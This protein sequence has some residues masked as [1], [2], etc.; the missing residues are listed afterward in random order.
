LLWVLTLAVTLGWLQPLA[1][2]ENTTSKTAPSGSTKAAEAKN[3]DYWFR[4]GALCAT[5]G[6]DKA[7][8]HFFQKAI[9]VNPRHGR[10]YFSQGVSYGQLGQHVKALAAIDQ[11]IALD[12]H[13]GLFYYG[14]GRVHLMSGE[15]DL[16][17]TDFRKAA[18]LGD[19]D[20]QVYLGE[21]PQ[22]VRP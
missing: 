6:N 7:A 21:L 18:E 3:S 5:Y 20:A 13:N 14:R 15:P 16:A 4:K 12:S 11:A 2:A 8:I 9:S 1:A 19:E 10:A 17:L 22:D